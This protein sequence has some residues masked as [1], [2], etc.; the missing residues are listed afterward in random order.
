MLARLRLCRATQRVRWQCHRELA[1]LF[2][3]PLINTHA[4]MRSLPATRCYAWRVRLP[5]CLP[6]VA[7]ARHA[8]DG[9]LSYLPLMP[10][11]LMSYAMPLLLCLRRRSRHVRF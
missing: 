5:R 3:R 4:M 2:T 10:L 8:A 9:A 7:V 1:R 11:P 6:S